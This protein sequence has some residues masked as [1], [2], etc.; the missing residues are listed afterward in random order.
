MNETPNLVKKEVSKLQNFPIMFFATI[1]GFSGL[2]MS[3]ERLN[4]FFHLSNV[5]FECIK[6][7][8]TTLFFII[9]VIYL[10]KL[11]KYPQEVKKEFFHPIKINFFA[12]FSISLLLLSIFWKTNT[13]VYSA[14]FYLG[15]AIQT[16][17]TF[18]V[19]SFWINN[20]LSINHSNP[21]WFIPIVGNLLVPLAD[22]NN[23]PFVW[24]YF[25]IGLFFWIILFTIIFYRIIF[26]DQLA[27]KFMPTLFIIIA[28]PAI[29]FVGYIKLTNSF[30]AMSYI[31]L[32][33]TIFFVVLI[34]FMYKNFLKMKFFLSWWA[35]TFP[36]AAASL[37]FSKAYELTHN[38]WFIMGSI[39]SFVGLIMLVSIVTFFTIK[40]IK[41][42][43]ICI[44]E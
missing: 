34:L 35:F 24:Y 32:N 17:L 22:I 31:F 39:F 41:N 26:H 27:K 42:G 5:V 33:L 40:S 13:S 28:P 43:E 6:Y 25:S 2:G 10:I 16:F 7:F 8:T 11:I 3:Y 23:A 29:A 18:Y 21:A 14:F 36:I 20:N 1:M 19:V 9:S 38:N 30:D 44:S 15:L 4:H 37:A 12:A